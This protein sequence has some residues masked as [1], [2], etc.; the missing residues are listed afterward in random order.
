MWSRHGRLRH[1]DLIYPL[2]G[3]IAGHGWPRAPLLGVA[4]CP[5]TIFTLGILLLAAGRV[6]VHVLVIPVLWS[7][8]GG[9]AAWL[10]GV[11]EALALP[12]A[13]LGACALLLCQNRRTSSA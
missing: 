7:L 13:G 5:T 3:W 9:S 2:L 10:L 12:V 6:P 8:V 4:P 11:T 1:G